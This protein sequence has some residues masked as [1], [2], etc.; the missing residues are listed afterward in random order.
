[1]DYIEWAESYEKTVE[2][3]EKLIEKKKKMLNESTKLW[4]RTEIKGVIKYYRSRISEL[5]S[6]AKHLRDIGEKQ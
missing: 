3:L 4:E 1:M 6:T 5:K 2:N